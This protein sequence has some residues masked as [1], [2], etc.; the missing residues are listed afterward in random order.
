MNRIIGIKRIKKI[1]LKKFKTNPDVSLSAVKE[2]NDF[3]FDLL[4]KIL[5]KAE[6]YRKIRNP[7][8][9]LDYKDVKLAIQQWVL[10]KLIEKEVKAW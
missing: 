4:L 10:K 6:E 1:Y 2:L 5:K 9:R 3:L 7:N 8:K